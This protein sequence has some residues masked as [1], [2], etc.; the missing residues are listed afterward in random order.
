MLPTSLNSRVYRP[1][2]LS[3]HWQ[4]FISEFRTTASHNHG[5]SLQVSVHH[6]E[7]RLRKCLID[8]TDLLRKKH[9]LEQSNTHQHDWFFFQ[10]TS[11]QGI[12]T[13]F[14]IV[15]LHQLKRISDETIR[16]HISFSDS[17]C[18]IKL[19]HKDD[20][21]GAQIA[22]SSSIHIPHA[23]NHQY[24]S[25]SNTKLSSFER[26]GNDVVN[27]LWL[28]ETA[29]IIQMLYSMRGKSKARATVKH[30]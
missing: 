25:S 15:K 26:E 24:N 1:L 14:K 23:T 2:P 5:A 7:S 4:N 30:K 21:V 3:S 18:S 22:A 9:M 10:S 27:P 17:C 20:K 11:P 29:R 28:C 13:G 8:T 16:L 19:Q 12:P 6:R